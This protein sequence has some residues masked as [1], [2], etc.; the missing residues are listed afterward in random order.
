MNVTNGNILSGRL[1]AVP[2][3]WGDKKKVFTRRR[4]FK[5]SQFQTWG[6]DILDYFVNGSPIKLSY[7]TMGVHEIWVKPEDV[8]E[9]YSVLALSC[10]NNFSSSWKKQSALFG[11]FLFHKDPELFLSIDFNSTDNQAGRVLKEK[12]LG[13]EFL[14]FLEEFN[15]LSFIKSHYGS[16]ANDRSFFSISEIDLVRRKRKDII[17][18]FEFTESE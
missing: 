11:A 13:K 12:Q 18:T 5:I 6:P 8:D 17:T 10:L 9:L 14:T 7:R 2:W 16:E 4:N 15:I 1:N 3:R